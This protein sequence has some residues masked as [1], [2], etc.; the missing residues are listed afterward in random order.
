M[1]S[2]PIHLH[3]LRTNTN[4]NSLKEVI[5]FYTK[6]KKKKIKMK[7]DTKKEKDNPVFVSFKLCKN[8]RNIS[9]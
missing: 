7:W 6:K 1:L 5:L 4:V 9:K 8:E 2:L 3:F